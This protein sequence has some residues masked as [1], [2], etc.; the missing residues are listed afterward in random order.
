M[1]QDVRQR[2][3]ELRAAL[4][5]ANHRYYVLDQ[6]TLSDAEYDRLMVELQELE[7]AYPE[8]V[9]PDSPTQRVG[10]PVRQEL[11]AVTHSQPMMSL[12]SIFAEEEL[13][14]FADTC[15]KASAS[16]VAYWAEPK[17]DGLAVE[18]VYVAGVLEVAA[19]RG[20]GIT[21]ENVTDNVRTIKQVPLRLHV[22]GAGPL[23]GPDTIRPAVTGASR[24]PGLD[25]ASAP[26]GGPDDIRPLLRPRP[27]PSR[28]EVRGEI[29]MRIADFEALNR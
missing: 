3:E 16:P 2:A 21:G 17:F 14:S 28:L 20:D 13:R 9:T 4:N 12:Q 25:E 15:A 24:L 11:G 27:I 29:Y 10:A 18:L 26:N 22:D 19:T 5:E 23:E 6:P 8:L 7:A 1:D